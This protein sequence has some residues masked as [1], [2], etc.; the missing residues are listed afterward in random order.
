MSPTLQMYPVPDCGYKNPATLPTYE[1]VY[2]DLDL[3]TRYGHPEVQ[4]PAASVQAWGGP[5]GAQLSRLPVISILIL[6]S[7]GDQHPTRPLSPA[8]V[9]KGMSSLLVIPR[10]WARLILATVIWA[11]ESAMTGVW[12]DLLV[13]LGRGTESS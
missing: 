6:S 10:A 12:A 4:K 3:H 2:K 9:A 7:D 5:G 8:L 13:T 1:I 11:P